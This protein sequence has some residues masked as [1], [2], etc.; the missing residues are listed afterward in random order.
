MEETMRTLISILVLSLV[1]AGALFL[2]SCSKSPTAPS[3]PP[4]PAT[5][6][7]YFGIA[8]NA[9]YRLQLSK[10]SNTR[11]YTPAIDDL[12]ELLMGFNLSRGIIQ[13][14]DDNTLFLKPEV[15]NTT[16]A[17]T[18]SPDGITHIAGTI[19]WIYGGTDEG[20]GEVTPIN[21][22]D[23]NFTD[24]R[25]EVERH[26][27]FTA[28]DGGTAFEVKGNRDDIVNDFIY[29][30]QIPATYQGK[31]VTR[32]YSG[33]M[34]GMPDGA[35]YY[36]ESLLTVKI[37]NSI[38]V[39]GNSAFVGCYKL[40][41][42]DIPGSVTTIGDVA[43]SGC[44]ELSSVSI[45]NSVTTIGAGAFSSCS[46]L[47]SIDIPG[48]VTA[49]GQGA[50]YSCRNLT[51][52][53]IPNGVTTIEDR[54][55]FNCVSLTNIHIPN[56]VTSIEEYAFGFCSSLTSINIPNSVTSLG[57]TAFYYCSSLT[58][59]TIPTG[60]TRIE[61]GVFERCTS[62]AS[63]TLPNGVTTID[64]YAFGGC[65]SLT[66]ITIPNSVTAIETGAFWD[67]TSMG[68]ISIPSSITSIGGNVFN[69]CSS[70]TSIEVDPANLHYS[71]LDGNLYNKEQTIIVR[72]A[73][74][75]PNSSFSIPE[76][77]TS[78]GNS[79]F[80]SSENLTSVVI[81]NNVTIIDE[82]AFAVCSNLASI[83]IP[84]S[85]TT[86][87]RL[88]FYYCE[89]LTSIIIP[90]SVMTIED[91]TFAI[92]S[93]MSVRFERANTAVSDYA[94]MGD[95][96]FKYMAGGSGTYNRLPNFSYEWEKVSD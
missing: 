43:F 25:F 71:T 63:V 4:V 13:E 76:S 32:I 48:S 66:N 52:I 57:P 86:I 81:G 15:A 60:I 51:N 82:Q 44:S 45:P 70:L 1:V 72:Y 41:S 19:S 17:V 96:S 77:V 69:G 20:P 33:N 49:I 29:A 2:G 37:P 47:T 67:C 8:D 59:I 58:S 38:T 78:I 73:S 3:E 88:A 89:S 12:Y 61:T 22:Y 79:A 21:P 46:S 42:I 24:P 93:L 30:I 14:L 16:F 36:C 95:L 85:V 31:P 56:S 7:T 62:L 68:N 94:F 83:S 40:Q 55:F 35:F 9:I 23:P 74:G 54:T 50:F 75:K 11:N 26:L 27:T 28:I 18:I 92:F 80:Y 91:N 6:T 5:S 10:P 65:S 84:N 34:G 64:E 39:I 53:T 87:K 90:N